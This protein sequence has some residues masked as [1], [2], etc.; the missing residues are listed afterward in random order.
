MNFSEI[1]FGEALRSK[2]IGT[3]HNVI[4]FSKLSHR[5]FSANI[6]KFL[7]QLSVTPFL[8]YIVN[9]KIRTH[10]KLDNIPL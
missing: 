8:N 4:F 7:E 5:H 2:E 10:V 3:L 9:E 1:L 6:T